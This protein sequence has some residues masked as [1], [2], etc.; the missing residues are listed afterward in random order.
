MPSQDAYDDILDRPIKDRD[1]P[2]GKLV[3]GVAI[4]I[5]VGAVLGVVTNTVAACMAGVQEFNLLLGHLHALEE[6]PTRRGTLWGGGIAMALSL[7][8]A[9]LAYALKRFNLP[10]RRMLPLRLVWL[11]TFIV[12]CCWVGSILLMFILVYTQPDLFVDTF[13]PGGNQ[14][15]QWVRTVYWTIGNMYGLG[16]GT[17][18]SFLAVTMAGVGRLPR[19]TENRPTG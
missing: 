3:V 19:P 13:L 17:L 5:L 18:G 14:D 2:A 11:C 16:L 1:Q 8:Y 10:V 6:W 15:R 4:F 7:W 9:L 12:L